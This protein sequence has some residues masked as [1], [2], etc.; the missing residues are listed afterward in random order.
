MYCSNCGKEI[1]NKAVICI[2]CGCAINNNGTLTDLPAELEHFNW[3]AFFLTWIW[4]IG[5]KTYIAFLILFLNLFC[6]IPFVGWTIPLAFSIW[7][8]CKGN[9][10][11]WNN[12]KWKD[13][14]YFNKIQRAW[15][16]WGAIISILGGVVCGII[17]GFIGALVASS[18]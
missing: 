13:T 5:N 9:E 6:L 7:L 4:G 14:E 2:H 10:Y 15:A 17:G 16:M 8:G 3:G 1:D 11:A 18:V 12:K